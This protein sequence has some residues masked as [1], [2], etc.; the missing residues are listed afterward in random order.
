M[1]KALSEFISYLKVELNYSDATTY[2]Y[3]KDVEKFLTFI[4]REDIMMDEVNLL[5]IRNFLS[6]ELANGV[7][8]RSCKRRLS[9]LKHFYAFLVKKTYTKDNPFIYISSPKIDKRYP[10]ILYPNQIEELLE[11]NKKRT[12]EFALRDQAILETLYFTG[13]RASELINIKLNDVDLGRRY[14]DVIGKGDK[15]RLVPFTP[16]CR[17][18]LEQYLKESR[19]F[20]AKK[21]SFTCDNFFLNE[22]GKSLTTRGLEYI[23]KKVEER[24]G[25]FVGL[26]PHLLRHSF[27][28]HLLDNGASLIEIQQLLGH[29]SLNT[30]QVYTH[31]TEEGLK[32]TY[33]TFHPRANKK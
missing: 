18:T 13:V 4:A 17:Q 9:S 10:Q 28:T 20:L 8:K 3:Q 25:I 31:V 32:S 21:G 24:T 7:S 19:P 6:D 12:D 29:S 11:E 26:H 1:N 5:V 33:K 14:I 16:S 30:T 15:E 22:F 27:A 23:L 2:N